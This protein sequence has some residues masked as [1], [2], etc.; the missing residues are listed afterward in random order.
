MTSYAYGVIR[1]NKAGAIAARIVGKY[2]SGTGSLVPATG[3]SLG[4]APSL[5]MDPAGNLY[6]SEYSGAGSGGTGYRVR[7]IES[8]TG[9]V[10]TLAGDGNVAAAGALASY[11]DASTVELRSP[12]FMAFDAAG[13]LHLTDDSSVRAIVGVGQSTAPLAT[14]SLA[15][16]NNQS[17]SIDQQVDT[18]LAVKLVDANA[19]TLKSGYTVTWKSTDVGA[20]LDSLTSDTSAVGV[21][22]ASA[23]SGLLPQDYHFTASY[24]DI[25]GNPVTGSPVAFT[26]TG[27]APTAGTIFSIVNPFHS[28]ASDPLPAAGTRVHLANTTHGV[29]VASDGTVY[30]S[31]DC[32]VKKISPAGIVS[33]VAGKQNAGVDGCG[34]NLGDGGPATQA[35]LYNAKGLALDEANHQL[36]VADSNNNVV[37]A[38]NLTDGTISTIAGGGSSVL[39]APYGDGGAPTSAY[40]P[41]PTHLSISGDTL[42]V[43]DSGHGSIRSISGLSLG[44][45]QNQHLHSAFDHAVRLA[46]CSHLRVRRR[47]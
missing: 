40:L 11:L 22:S 35:Q 45:T 12:G 26:I 44:G 30:F 28:A 7:R 42:Y 17:V 15:A 25:H 4:G 19:V 38:I 6:V 33:Q 21:A 13:T 37:R 34:S 46:G 43:T 24:N 27:A 39:A 8:G 14:L 2:N 16:G 9:R 10:V 36:Y 1:V 23:W 18:P 31:T 5:A 32:A 3:V 29:A 20:A 47:R 41:T